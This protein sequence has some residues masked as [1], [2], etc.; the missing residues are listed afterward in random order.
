MAE[1][2]SCKT[3][4]CSAQDEMVNTKRQL[5][6]GLASM[7]KG[8]TKIRIVLVNVESRVGKSKKGRVYKR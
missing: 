3:P 7:S 6:C 5:Y 1:N 8:S 2:Q 4:L